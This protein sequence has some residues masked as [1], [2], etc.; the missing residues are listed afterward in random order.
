MVVEL[1]EQFVCKNSGYG[2]CMFS[3]DFFLSVAMKFSRSASD[4]ASAE[5]S[6]TPH[7]APRM[8]YLS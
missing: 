7:S 8:Q 1:L 4:I 5:Q 6:P 2:F 3:S